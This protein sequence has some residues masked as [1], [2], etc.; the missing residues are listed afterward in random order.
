MD[1]LC[2]VIEA[3]CEDDLRAACQGRQ[4]SVVGL[5]ARLEGSMWVSF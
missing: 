2:D 3:R 4:K 5:E 1:I